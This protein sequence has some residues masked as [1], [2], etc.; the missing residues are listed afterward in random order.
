MRGYFVKS[1]A[2]LNWRGL[3]KIVTTVVASAARAWRMS[4]RWP[5]WSQPIVGTRPT[6]R[7]DA[8]QG[9]AELGAGADDL[10]QA[11]RARR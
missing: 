9:V 2:T 6:G 1:A 8:G 3:T 7:G 4:A 10:G 5:S 11:S